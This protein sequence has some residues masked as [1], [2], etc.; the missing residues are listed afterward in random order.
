MF[1]LKRLILALAILSFVLIYT[2][3]KNAKETKGVIK[4][5]PSFHLKDINGKPIDSNNFIGR[6]LY[7]QFLNADVE[8]QVQL[9]INVITKYKSI[10]TVSI[11]IVNNFDKL[12]GN[13]FIDTIKRECL[14]I[15]GNINKYKKM[16][17]SPSCCEMYY[18]FDNDRKLL[19]SNFNWNKLEN[20]EL[21]FNRIKK[22]T[23]FTIFSLFKIGDYIYANK[24]GRELYEY[25]IKN[26][27]GQWHLISIFS[28]ICM[29][30]L[31]GSVID[32]I[33]EIEKYCKKI[34]ITTFL[35]DDFTDRD[36]INAKANLKLNFNVVKAKFNIAKE[37]AGLKNK[38]GKSNINN[39]IIVINN[40]GTILNLFDQN[41]ISCRKSFFNDIRGK[42]CK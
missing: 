10:D 21:D 8:Y 19:F 42:I 22:E 3:N 23:A 38:Y 34:S 13:A 29:S 12:I 25:V 28:S 37:I 30:C 39:L 27:K 7:I 18:L 24:F 15:N 9:L 41:C 36:V 40:E 16:F 26:N 4:E 17:N 1:K 5:I 20:V 11:I 31:S 35:T 14:I 2:Y 33:I 32:E 6:K